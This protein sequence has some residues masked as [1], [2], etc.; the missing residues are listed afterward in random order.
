ML[1]REN[2]LEWED[3]EVTGNNEVH[4]YTSVDKEELTGLVLQ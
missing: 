1:S 4:V 3:Y 2:D